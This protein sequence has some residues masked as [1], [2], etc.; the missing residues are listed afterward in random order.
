MPRPIESLELSTVS[1][2]IEWDDDGNPSKIE[3]HNVLLAKCQDN[4]I[5]LRDA[6]KCEWREIK[7][8]PTEEEIEKV[9]SQERLKRI[10]KDGPKDSGDICFID[11]MVKTF[12]AQRD[13]S[14][15]YKKVQDI[16]PEDDE[17]FDDMDQLHPSNEFSVSSIW[18]K[19]K[20]FAEKYL[21][22]Q[23]GTA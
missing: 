12:L 19:L 4:T 5:W 2:P 15:V 11:D 13:E 16:Y 10:M 8:I 7:G 23:S 20:P 3:I 18:E 9:E 22:D 14:A 17:A 21:G 1:I 6:R